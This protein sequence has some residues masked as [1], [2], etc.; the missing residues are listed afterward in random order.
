M[1]VTSPSVKAVSSWAANDLY[2][3]IAG[4]EHKHLTIGSGHSPG[5]LQFAIASANTSVQTQTPPLRIQPLQAIVSEL[6]NQNASV[7]QYCQ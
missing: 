5:K 3:M 1:I 7:I 6:A 4:I 2:T